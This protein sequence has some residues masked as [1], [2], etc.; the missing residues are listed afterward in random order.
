[1]SYDGSVE[2]RDAPYPFSDVD[3]RVLSLLSSHTHAALQRAQTVADLVRVGGG[4]R[5]VHT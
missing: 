5:C 2:T 3:M 4:V 1:M